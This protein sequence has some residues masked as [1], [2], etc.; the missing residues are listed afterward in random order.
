MLLTRTP[1][2][3]EIEPDPV[4]RGAVRL[5]LQYF[6]GIGPISVSVTE[7]VV[8]GHRKKFMSDYAIGT[9]HKIWLNPDHSLPEADL[10]W[11]LETILS[12]LALLAFAI[13]LAR[14]GRRTWRYP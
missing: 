8:S 5:K 11:S 7:P 9:S 10:V 14:N 3:S 4:D 6:T 1:A 2:V 12:S 13:V